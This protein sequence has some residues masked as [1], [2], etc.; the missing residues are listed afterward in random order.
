MYLFKRGSR[1]YI[2]YINEDG[3]EI[4][5]STGR[6][7]KVEGTEFLLKFKA[8]QHQKKLRRE[9]KTLSDFT[10]EFERHSECEHTPKTTSSYRTAM[11]EFKRVM[12]DRQLKDYGVRDV[13]EFIL[14]KRSDHSLHSVRSYHAHLSAAFETAKRWGYIEDNPFRKVKRVKFPEAPPIFLTKSQF[15]AILRITQAQD[16]SDVLVAAVTTGM[17]LGE[18]MVLCWEDVSLL[19]RTI[20]IR[21]TEQFTTKNRKNRVIPMNLALASVLE[22]RKTMNTIKVFQAEGRRFVAETVSKGFKQLVRV[23]GLNEKLHFHSLRHTF[24]SWLVQDGVS[25]YEVQKLLGQS[26]VTFHRSSR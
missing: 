4:R 11:T 5:V 13:E 14:K 17:R 1:Y 12:E 8:D 2:S 22:R 21:N 25:L 26:S 9:Q 18:L 10:K 19:N 7:T 24:A 23:C 15:Q 6:K 20:F 16:L 3:K